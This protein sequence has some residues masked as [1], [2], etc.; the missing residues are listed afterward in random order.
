MV[1]KL[2]TG[3]GQLNPYSN[4][5]KKSLLLS[6]SC[7]WEDWTIVAVGPQPC[8]FASSCSRAR[9][10]AY[11]CFP[12]SLFSQPQPFLLSTPKSK[13][14][15]TTRSKGIKIIIA[16]KSWL[17]MNDINSVSNRVLFSH[18][19]SPG[20]GIFTFISPHWIVKQPQL[21]MIFF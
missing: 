10:Q 3:L 2:Y 5:M 20:L 16:I 17:V 15:L 18:Y 13:L 1:K 11:I 6:A 14:A 7:S 12:Q 8:S 9:T 19:V 21:A 4:S